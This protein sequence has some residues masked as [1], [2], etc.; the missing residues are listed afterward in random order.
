MA[1]RD[2]KPKYDGYKQ[3]GDT[4]QARIEREKRALARAKKNAGTDAIVTN[5]VF[6]IQ[7]TAFQEACKLADVKPTSRQ[8]SKYR[9]RYGAAARAAGINT[10]QDP[11]KT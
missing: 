6:A 7:D 10:R 4:V 3:D 5:E 1:K 9:H 2:S 8:A 11:R